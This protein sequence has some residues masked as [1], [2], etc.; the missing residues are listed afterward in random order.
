MAHKRKLRVISKVRYI[1]LL[2]F[3]V[4]AL[5]LVPALIPRA[6]ANMASAKGKAPEAVRL[7]NTCSKTDRTPGGGPCARHVDVAASTR[8][9]L[10]GDELLLSLQ[11]TSRGLPERGIFA[12]RDDYTSP[13]KPNVLAALRYTTASFAKSILLTG[14]ISLWY[15]FVQTGE[16]ERYQP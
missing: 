7:C 10:R 13:R 4:V 5:F 8:Q 3:L 16:G 14:T 11:T 12:A 15:D 2:L 6:H 9:P 1:L